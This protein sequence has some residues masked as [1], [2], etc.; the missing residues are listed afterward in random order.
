MYCEGQIT[1]T[2]KIA[3]SDLLLEYYNEF[4][5]SIFTSKSAMEL[6][7]EHSRTNYHTVRF[8]GGLPP[9][10]HIITPPSA[11]SEIESKY[12]NEILHAYSDFLGE[13]ILCA[14]ELDMPC[15]KKSKL[16]VDLLR[17]RERFYHAESLRN[18]ARDTVP[19]GTFLSLQE[20]LFHGVV[21]TC[22]DEHPNG[23]KRMQATL[24]KASNLIL[25]SNP[26]IQAIRVQDK[27]GICHQLVNDDKMK[28]V[29]DDE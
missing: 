25:T 17:Q 15:K 9:R 21:D 22:D 29:E 5:F 1:K 14:D 13:H 20:E 12:V 2:N 28:W 23:Y 18:F 19:E 27:Q 6:L 10:P 4:D 24:E 26:L 8:G 3:L 7:D 16:K 11:L